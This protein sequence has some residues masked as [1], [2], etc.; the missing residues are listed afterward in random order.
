[1]TIEAIASV[2]HEANRAYCVALGDLSQP[3][4]GDAPEW[5]RTS[6]VA[7]VEFILA[8][9]NASHSASHESWLAEKERDGWAWGPVKDAGAKLHPCFVPFDQLPLEQQAKDA[10][11]GA[12]VRALAPL[13]VPLV[14]TPVP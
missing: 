6:A 11:F 14:F 3:A 12:V 1:M 5:Q 7:G 8:N 9:P 2:A 4:W 13:V 10:M